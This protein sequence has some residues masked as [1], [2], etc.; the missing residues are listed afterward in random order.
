[1]PW[2]RAPPFSMPQPL[3]P[4]MTYRAPLLTAD[5]LPDADL[6][7]LLTD[8]QVARLAVW[9]I[10]TGAPVLR[11]LQGSRFVAEQ[12]N[13]SSHQL[14]LIGTLPDCGLFGCLMPDG[15]THT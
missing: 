7:R 3:P 8:A 4:A 11:L 6:F 12:V 13:A 2:R 1:M 15:S 9:S 14:S 5:N 10:Q